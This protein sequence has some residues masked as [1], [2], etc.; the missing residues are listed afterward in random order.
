MPSIIK[1]LEIRAQLPHHDEARVVR[2]DVTEGSDK[3][4]GQVIELQGLDSFDVDVNT[5]N[6]AMGG[7]I[8]YNAT[9]TDRDIVL[10]VK[11]YFGFENTLVNLMSEYQMYSTAS[12]EYYIFLD[13]IASD[14]VWSCPIVVT[15]ASAPI[16]QDTDEVTIE[17]LSPKHLF[18]AQR[19]ITTV[20]VGDALL[21]DQEGTLVQ[22]GGG[23]EIRSGSFGPRK[24]KSSGET[25]HGYGFWISRNKTGLGLGP[26]DY[27]LI[28]YTNETVTDGLIFGIATLSGEF[29][30]IRLFPSRDWNAQGGDVY[31]RFS[32]IG[33]YHVGRDY[34][35]IIDID[36]SKLHQPIFEG[37]RGVTKLMPGGKMGFVGVWLPQDQEGWGTIGFSRAFF[38]ETRLGF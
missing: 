33:D 12:N 9:P 34:S 16:M 31:T 32:S 27:D 11:P 37:R 21:N 14:G 25:L 3:S 13:V 10:R 15:S 6:A 28:L 22:Q 35:T 23:I 18:Y 17:L 36:P 2:L 30:G 24:F 29:F 20:R 8:L 26:V 19:D 1:V 4:M 5:A 7:S 38:R